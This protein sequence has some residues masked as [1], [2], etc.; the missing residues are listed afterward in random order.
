MAVRR[1]GDQGA[2]CDPSEGKAGSS[3]GIFAPI[4]TSIVSVRTATIRLLGN[5]KL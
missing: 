4:T 2:C 3:S 1:D 5:S